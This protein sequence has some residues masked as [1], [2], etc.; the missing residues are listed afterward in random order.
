MTIKDYIIQNY[1]WRDQT[2]HILH[3]SCFLESSFL[4]GASQSRAAD[5]SWQLESTLI[6]SEDLFLILFLLMRQT[7]SQ[8]SDLFGNFRND[9]NSQVLYFQFWSVI[10]WPSAA[11]CFWNSWDHHLLPSAP[12]L[13][14]KSVISRLMVTGLLTMDW[15]FFFLWVPS[16]SFYMRFPWPKS[17]SNAAISTHS[18]SWGV[19][20]SFSGDKISSSSFFI[21]YTSVFVRW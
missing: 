15:L 1:Q 11:W 2:H 16:C 5:P 14:A 8:S 21:F 7:R 18:W 4:G 17:C 6:W 3:T 12:L 19:I 9:L 13:T 20:F 10:F